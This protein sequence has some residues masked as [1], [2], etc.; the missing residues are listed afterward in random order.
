[1]PYILTMEAQSTANEPMDTIEATNGTAK[2]ILHVEVTRGHAQVFWPT[3]GLHDVDLQTGDVLSEM[4]SLDGIYRIDCETGR[5]EGTRYSVCADMLPRL[6]EAAPGKKLRLTHDCGNQV[7]A[8][9]DVVDALPSEGVLC[10]YA[11][12]RNNQWNIGR[13]Y[14]TGWRIEGEQL[15]WLRKKAGRAKAS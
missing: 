3:S 9:V 13:R 4:L 8:E 1:M 11:S 14:K 10:V 7:C 6:G 12:T 5:V 15:E 2:K